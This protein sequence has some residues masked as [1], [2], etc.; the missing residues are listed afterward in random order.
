MAKRG[1]AKE[2]TPQAVIF[3]CGKTRESGMAVRQLVE[4]KLYVDVSGLVKERGIWI[5]K[6]GD[7]Q[8]TQ[9]A[10][11]QQEGAAAKVAAAATVL[12][13]NG[14]CVV[15]CDNGNHRSRAVAE[16]AAG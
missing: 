5:R 16:L 2:L 4:K 10:V 15:C 8:A 11:L 6:T 14:L 13:Q 9:R 7:R 3:S 1:L 12:I